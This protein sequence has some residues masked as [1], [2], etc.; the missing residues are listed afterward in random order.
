MF[1]FMLMYSTWGNCLVFRVLFKL[2]KLNNIELKLLDYHWI[3]DMYIK[4]QKELCIN[5]DK[6]GSNQQFQ[7]IVLNSNKAIAVIFIKCHGTTP[8]TLI[9]SF[10]ASPLVSLFEKLSVLK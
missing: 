9:L 3:T 5:F 8:F 4:L 1:L 10:N 2:I 6:N 7:I